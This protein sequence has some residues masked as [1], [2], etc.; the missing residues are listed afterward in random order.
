MPVYKHPKS[1]YY[2][3]EFQL[4]GHSFRGSSK[5]KNK[6][7]A[8]ALEREWRAQAAKDIKERKRSVSGPPTLSMAAGRYM[9]EVMTGKASEADTY[10]S[11]ERLIKSIGGATRMDQITDAH[12]A[13]FIAKRRKDHRY[14]KKK[15]QDDSAMGVVSNATINRETAVLKRLFM[16]ARRTWKLTLP[17]EPDWRGHMLPEEV[18]RVREIHEDEADILYS[19][20]RDD[21]LPWL[22]FA[23]MSGLRLNETLLRWTSVN[24]KTGLIRT[25]GKGNKWVVTQI[26][27]SIRSVLEPLV[28]HHPEFV[29]TYVAKRTSKAGKKIRGQRYP[30]T[31]SGIQSYWRRFKE[32]SGLD[33][34]RIHDIRHDAASKIVRETGNLKVGQKLLNHSSVSVTAKYAHVLDTEV[35]EA[36]ERVAKSRNNSRNSQKDGS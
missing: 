22:E 25:K 5:T 20:L 7:E 4:H 34:L 26:T 24:W 1:P 27:P 8:E 3:I 9:T 18:E 6:K 28:G 11:L 29:F 31:Y 16:R 32:K 12:V 17:N 21:Y 13:S 14:G 2:Q 36:M 19:G 15:K 35:A 33:D 23:H 10:R 30:L